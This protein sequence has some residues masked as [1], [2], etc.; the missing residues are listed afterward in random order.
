V[1]ENT[2]EDSHLQTNSSNDIILVTVHLVDGV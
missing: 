2:L 1:E